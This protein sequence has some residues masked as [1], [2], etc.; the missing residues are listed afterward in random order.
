LEDHVQAVAG[1]EYEFFGANSDMTACTFLGGAGG[2]AL[3]WRVSTREEFGLSREGASGGSE[4]A[5]LEVCDGA[6]YTEIPGPTLI[7]EVYSE[8]QGRAYN[9]TIS[10]APSA[11]ALEW[12]TELL[13][14]VC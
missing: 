4:V 7:M 8:D 13:T 6:F 1:P 3:A 12:A 11:D 2:I 9:A 10:G 5:D 14:G